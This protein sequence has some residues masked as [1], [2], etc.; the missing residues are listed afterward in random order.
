[1]L[2]VCV[3]DVLGMWLLL[4][5][6]TARLACLPWAPGAGVESTCLERGEPFLTL[7]SCVTEDRL[8][9]GVPWSVLRLFAF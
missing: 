1:M 3:P 2:P 5:S 4:R 6:V 7:S 9:H 8:V